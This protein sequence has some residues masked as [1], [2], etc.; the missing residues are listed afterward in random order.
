MNLPAS[1]GQSFSPH[2]MLGY[3]SGSLFTRPIASIAWVA[4]EVILVHSEVGRTRHNELGRWQL[5][6]R[7]GELF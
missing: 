4:S 2:L 7:Q 5:V 3:P 1:A 6:A